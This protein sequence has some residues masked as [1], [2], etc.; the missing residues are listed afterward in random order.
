MAKPSTRTANVR[1]ANGHKTG[2]RA[3]I[4]AMKSRGND[5]LKYQRGPRGAADWPSALHP[6]KSAKSSSNASCLG[7]EPQRRSICLIASSRCS[8]KLQ[9]ST[10]KLELSTLVPLEYVALMP[11]LSDP[12]RTLRPMAMNG[13]RTCA[14][15]H[16]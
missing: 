9:D 16:P 2:A 11:S 12:E 14:S 4:K 8:T 15:F 7:A 5:G 1:Q 10:P 13:A 6:A 3:A